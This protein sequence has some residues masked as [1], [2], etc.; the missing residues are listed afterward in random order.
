MRLVGVD[1]ARVAGELVRQREAGVAGG[2]EHVP[3]DAVAADL[4]AAVD[5]GD[6]VDPAGT[7][8][9]SQRLRSRSSATWRRNSSTV[10]R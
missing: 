3:E 10:G 1:D 7:K 5:G 4:E 2:D 9:S 8:L 6:P